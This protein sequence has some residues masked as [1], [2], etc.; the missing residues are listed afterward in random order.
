MWDVSY[1]DGA[2]DGDLDPT[3][4]Y[5]DAVSIASSF[6]PSTSEQA[7]RRRT[8]ENVRRMFVKTEMCRYYE[9]GKCSRG[10]E[11]Y[12]AHGSHEMRPRAVLSKTSMCHFWAKNR[13]NQGKACR[14]AHNSNELRS[15]RQALSTQ[16]PSPSE[17][18]KTIGTQASRKMPVFELPARMP[19]INPPCRGHCPRCSRLEYDALAKFCTVCGGPLS[20]NPQIDLLKSAEHMSYFMHTQEAEAAE[21]PW[22]EE[23]WFVNVQV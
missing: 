20:L 4:F 9:K 18:G 16:I 10:E 12:F 14:F 7:P 8:S 21:P 22:M 15:A 23:P 6:N 13:C 3:Q 11:C 2:G 19:D 1:A 5:L 17:G